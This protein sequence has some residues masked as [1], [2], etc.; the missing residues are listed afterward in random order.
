MA[1]STGA[2]ALLLFGMNINIGEPTSKRATHE[3]SVWSGVFGIMWLL[4][5]WVGILFYQTAWR[6]RV[7]WW[8][9]RVRG[10]F[11]KTLAVFWSACGYVRGFRF[12]CSPFPCTRAVCTILI[13]V[14][15]G[16][17]I[18]TLYDC[19][20]V[21]CCLSGIVLAGII[22]FGHTAVELHT[23]T[24]IVRDGF[25]LVVLSFVMVGLPNMCG[26]VSRQRISLVLGA[27]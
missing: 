5:V 8:H 25:Y 15:A 7:L 9:R 23:N 10:L 11:P 2:H 18:P 27:S 21:V 19:S 6:Y 1:L 4:L 14:S 13:T 20:L 22:V 16:A 12:S 17:D 24:R 26:K 3:I